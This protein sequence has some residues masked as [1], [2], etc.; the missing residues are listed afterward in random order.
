MKYIILSF[1][2]FVMS[3]S[4]SQAND[5]EEL[6]TQQGENYVKARESKLSGLRD[7]KH[8][9]AQHLK[10]KAKLLDSIINERS[11]NRVPFDHVEQLVSQDRERRN[12]LSDSARKK[13]LLGRGQEL[14]ANLMYTMGE[15][16]N[17]LELFKFAVVEHYWKLDQDD[18][19]KLCS[20]RVLDYLASRNH[21]E[22]S[23]VDLVRNDF[24]ASEE[25]SV[26]VA[27]LNLLSYYSGQ[28]QDP[29]ISQL[30]DD[31]GLVLEEETTPLPVVKKCNYLLSGLQEK[32]LPDKTK[33]DIRKL[34]DKCEWAISKQPPAPESEAMKARK[35]YIQSFNGE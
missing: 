28:L 11:K 7:R 24:I 19:E 21:F 1:V 4:L 14:S 16:T 30:I 20:L 3:L 26:R 13:L 2:C 18:Y 23:I 25:P 9:V 15:K 27:A 5:Y 29:T 22:S 35:R 6:L 12:Q 10:G 33:E 8:S 32:A 17:D 31:I 34:I